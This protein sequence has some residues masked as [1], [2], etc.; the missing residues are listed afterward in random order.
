MSKKRQ[1]ATFDRLA[2]D[3]NAITTLTRNYA[4]NHVIPLH[5]HNRD[6]LVYATR[7]VMTVQTDEGAWV[8]PTHRGVWIP[9]DVVH[10]IAMSGPVAMRT[11]YLKPRLVKALP[12][13]CCVV[14]ISPLLKELIVEACTVGALKSRVLTQRHLID[15]IID[16]M[17]VVQT[18]PLQL[19]TLTDP[20][21]LRVAD[22]L[23]ADPGNRQSLSQ[24]CE[25]SGASSRTIERIF[26]EE[27]AMTV[28][29]WRQQLR[30]MHAMRLLGE[31]EK[32]TYAAQEAGYS[33]PSAFIAAFRKMLGTTPTHY[34]GRTS[35]EGSVT[36][37]RRTRAAR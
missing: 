15:V 4:A 23:L 21:A 33:A 3:G 17:Q 27:A 37:V 13:T 24:I 30:L 6:Q 36:L 18:V 32:V 2:S 25:E 22:A 8:V 1:A 9:K 26:Q 35:E 5:F 16:Q 14:N 12:R 11:L 10:T 28:G 19:P 34:F 31:G 29:K 20:R 7:G